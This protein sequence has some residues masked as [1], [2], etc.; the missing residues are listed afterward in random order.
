MMAAKHPVS[1]ITGEAGRGKTYVLK[2]LVEW[3]IHTDKAIA[4]AA[5]T[6]KLLTG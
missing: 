6:G 1:I 3:F 5:P 4:L 2:T